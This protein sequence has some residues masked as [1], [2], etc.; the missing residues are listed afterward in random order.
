MQQVD[1]PP[2]AEWRESG[3]ERRGFALKADRARTLL[4]GDLHGA[5][6]AM[7]AM[8]GFAAFPGHLRVDGR[9]VAGLPAHRR[10]VALL[11][12]G[13]GLPPVERVRVAELVARTARGRQA[14]EVALEIAGLTA[15]Q[16]DARLGDLDEGVRLRVALARAVATMPRL[17]LL[18]RVLDA[19]DPAA[20]R[21]ALFALTAIQSRLDVGV[22]AAT[23]RP[24]TLLGTPIG[25]PEL[26]AVVVAGRVVQ[27]APPQTLYDDPVGLT[28]LDVLGP[29]NL[30]QARLID[31]DPDGVARCR[32][33]GGST[34]EGE[35]VE[36][37]AAAGKACLVDVRPERIALAPGGDLVGE[38]GL[39]G[40]VLGVSFEGAWATLSVRLN[41]GGTQLRVRRPAGV[42]L[43]RMG[44]GAE[45]SLA[46]QPHHAR[47]WSVA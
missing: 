46:W 2:I 36:P 19:L 25:V 42:P 32:L 11:E 43:G 5:R 33:P 24:A 14:L 28:V 39:V 4:V 12:P 47:V 17:L 13:L 15:E 20:L 3:P 10:K 9:D 37:A 21:A 8:A 27:C 35:V 45:V 1:R 22:V 26:V 18:D 41:A 29:T 23:Q 44:T 34:V 6:R 38:G 7:E 30:L 31:V 40:S 16:C